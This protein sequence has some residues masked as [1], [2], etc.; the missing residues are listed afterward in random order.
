MDNFREKLCLIEWKTSKRQKATID[1]TFDN[2]L[3]VAAYMGAVNFDQQYDLNVSI[4]LH[5]GSFDL[6]TKE[7]STIML[8]P[9]GIVVALSLCTGPLTTGL[10]IKHM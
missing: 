3:Q 4:V 5:F 2:P 10:D 6:S 7:P 9:P 8:C 1:S